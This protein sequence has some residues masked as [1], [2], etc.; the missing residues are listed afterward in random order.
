MAA[1]ASVALEGEDAQQILGQVFRRTRTD[2]GLLRV[3]DRIQPTGPIGMGRVVHGCIASGE[4]VIDEVVVGCEG[5][6]SFVI[7][8]HGNP[9]LV[10]RIVGM[11]QSYGAVLK[12]VNTFLFER[13]RRQSATLIE[14]EAKLAMQTSATTAGVRI[15]QAQ[16][17]S[18][19]TQWA[20]QTLKTIDSID[21]GEIRQQ[22]RQIL[23]QSE[24]A[25]RIIEGVRIVIAGPPNSGKSTLLNRLAGQQEAIVSDTAGAT[26]DWVSIECRLEPFCVEFFDTAG[27]DKNLAGQGAVDKRAQEIARELIESCDLVLYV[28]DV[29]VNRI[30]IERATDKP[31]VYVYNKCDLLPDF[32]CSD[33]NINSVFVSAKKGTGIELLAGMIRQALGANSIDVHIP[34]VFT[35]RQRRILSKIT[36]SKRR[37]TKLLSDLVGFEK[38]DKK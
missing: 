38:T 19:L 37:P 28:Q 23:E 32:K 16:I 12:D 17:D 25:R 4:E 27:L 14:A 20:D 6:G 31:V 8:C 21:T 18:G 33:S 24:V 35:E 3:T 10:E 1:I 2:V 13:Y 30:D 11:L 36:T 22:A 5:P 7:H 29:T 15:L 34:V 26:R 9:L